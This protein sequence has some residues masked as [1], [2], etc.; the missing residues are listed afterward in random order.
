MKT[1]NE[2]RVAIL[3]LQ[4]NLPEASDALFDQL[5][6]DGDNE[7]LCDFYVIESGSDDDKLSKYCKFHANWPEAIE[8]GMHYCRGMN[9]GLSELHK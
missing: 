4:R 6:K 5:I 8:K 7:K 3:L 1:N 9:Y 2:K